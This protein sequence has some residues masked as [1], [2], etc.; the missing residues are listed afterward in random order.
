MPFV[1]ARPICTTFTV[2]GPRGVTIDLKVHRR[3]LLPHSIYGF[4]RTPF[5][6]L[7][8]P[9]DRRFN[10]STAGA[11]RAVLPLEFPTIILKISLKTSLIRRAM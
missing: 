8:R 10:T 9:L 6:A 11:D 7:P 3:H 2:S 1:Q 4:R 5:D